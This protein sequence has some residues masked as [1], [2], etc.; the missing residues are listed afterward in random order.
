[1]ATKLNTL[2]KG[3]LKEKGVDNIKRIE[4]Q[5]QEELGV[6]FY[7]EHIDNISIQNKNIIITTK[8]SEA[9]AEVNLQKTTIKTN[10]TIKVL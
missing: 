5:L 6:K 4:Q 7:K 2:I 8:S 10:K 3:F 9:R 1:M